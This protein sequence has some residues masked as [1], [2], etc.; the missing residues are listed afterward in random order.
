MEHK[1][2]ETNDDEWLEK[3]LKF[4]NYCNLYFEEQC[5]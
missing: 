2:I 4:K 3:R 1:T 5:N